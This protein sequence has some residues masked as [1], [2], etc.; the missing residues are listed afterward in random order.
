MDK[1]NLYNNFSGVVELTEK[2]FKDK[3]KNKTKPSDV[4][5]KLVNPDFQDK[6]GL[7]FFYAPWCGHCKK[8]VEPMSEL[9]IQF[10]YIFPIGAVNCE[11]TKNYNVCSQYGVQAFPTIFQKTAQNKLI[12]YRGAYDK[13]T[14]LEYIYQNTL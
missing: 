7:V 6:N 8:M 5:P 12:P 9:A 2:D 10:R 14:I 3:G 4:P 11:N 1:K 13:D